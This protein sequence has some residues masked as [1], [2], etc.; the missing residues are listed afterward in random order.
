MLFK[1]NVKTETFPWVTY[2]IIIINIL[3]FVPML[4]LD[5]SEKDEIYAKYGAI[6]AELGFHNIYTL[7]TYMFI[8]AGI[9]H[10]VGNMVFLKIFGDNVEDNLGKFKFIV[11]YLVCG[12]MAA[13]VHIF[14]NLDSY[15]PLV[16]ASGAI[17]GMI[18]AYLI[19]YGLTAK[20]RL[21]TLGL[22]LLVYSFTSMFLPFEIIYLLLGLLLPIAFGKLNKQT[23][24]FLAKLTV[25]V[26]VPFYLVFKIGMDLIGASSFKEAGIAFLAHLGGFAIGI[27]LIL[28]LMRGKSIRGEVVN[29][30]EE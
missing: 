16:G 12:M 9:L 15:G 19:L 7:I 18:G 3:V 25:N 21:L 30:T 8:H 26:S 14:F 24:E 20:L 6:P 29:A 11:F 5:E 10:L 23:S 1:D 22:V 4:F 27:L 2:T 13:F 28:Y 17:Y